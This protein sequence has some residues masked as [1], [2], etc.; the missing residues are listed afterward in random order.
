M[1]WLIVVWSLII[2]VASS[3]A[4]TLGHQRQASLLSS[5]DFP[6]TSSRATKA[7]M[8]GMYSVSGGS[9]YYDD[10]FYFRHAIVA[11]ADPLSFSPLLLPASNA[12]SGYG[13]DKTNV[14]YFNHVIPDAHPNSFV[15]LGEVDNVGG[16][17][18]FAED[19]KQVYVA[20]I[21]IPKADPA[22]FRIMTEPQR[23]G[24]GCFFEAIDKNFLYYQDEAVQPRTAC[25]ATACDAQ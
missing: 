20:S 18:I 21:P 24:D 16:N 9:V 15:V 8:N 22:T 25:S 19:S 4:P 17:D 12:Q 14:Y 23:C 1:K 11:D 13:K 3:F 5:K 10:G 6:A 2:A 7:A